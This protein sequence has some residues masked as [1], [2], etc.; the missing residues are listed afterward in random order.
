MAGD[1]VVVLQ[2]L[3]GKTVTGCD[4]SNEYVW[5]LPCAGGRI[6]RMDEHNDRLRLHLTLGEG[7]S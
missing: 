6:I 7:E 4:Y 1:T 5:V 2:H 3:S